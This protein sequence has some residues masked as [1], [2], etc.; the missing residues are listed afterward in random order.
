MF[1]EFLEKDEKEVFFSLALELVKIDD[2]FTE[3]E[4]EKIKTLALRFLGNE[5]YDIENL[6]ADIKIL[7]N[8]S[9]KKIVLTELVSLSYID[10]NYCDKEKEHIH[11]LSKKLGVEKDVMSEIE[12]WVLEFVNHVQKGTNLINQ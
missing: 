11:S 12:E 7:E 3:G 10:G 9:K 1:I 8:F 2:D 4:K 6:N 5:G